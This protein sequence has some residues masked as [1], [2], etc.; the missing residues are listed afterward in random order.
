MNEGLGVL[1]MLPWLSPPRRE[2]GFEDV[3]TF[4]NYG[5]EL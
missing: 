1:G 5:G 2:F 3:F 4:G